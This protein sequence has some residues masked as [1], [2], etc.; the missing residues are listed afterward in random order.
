MPRI[1]WA[2]LAL[3]LVPSVAAAQ[4]PL[5]LDRAVQAVLAGNAGLA[6][7]RAGAREADASADDVRAGLF[8]RVTVSESWQR[9]NEPVFVF[10]SILSARRFTASNFALDFLNHPPATSAFRTTIAADQVVFD[11]GRRSA[12]EHSARRQAEAAALFVDARAADLVGSA[13]ATFGRVLAAQA[14]ERAAAGGLESAREDHARAERRRDAGLAT[15]AD[16]LSLA[17]HVADLERRRI[18]ARGDAAVAI[19]ALNRLMGQ[20]IQRAWLAVAPSAVDEPAA[21][22]SIEALFAEADAARPEVRRAAALEAAAREQ[23]RGAARLLVPQAVVQGAVDFAGTQFDRRASAWVAGAEFRWTWSAG[24]GERA[25]RRAAA[26]GVARARAEAEEARAAA[27]VDVLT[28][29]RQL[30]TARARR[31]ASRTAVDQARESHRIVRD[32]FE[33]GVAAVND[34]LRASTAMLDAEAHDVEAS[35]DAIVAAAALRRALGRT[36]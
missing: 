29:L 19:A 25:R 8:P 5:T 26:E 36:P 28:A 12:A 9:A 10:G 18:Q 13:V 33:A 27:H 11:G 34:V 2:A 16:V 7:A 14:S 35:V 3:A 4:D 17:V 32:R 1:S 30:D 6:A 31:G 21:P 22:A 24:G 23:S 20:P 15:D